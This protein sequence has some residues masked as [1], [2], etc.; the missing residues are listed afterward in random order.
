MTYPDEKT[1]KKNSATRIKPL[2]DEDK[3][4]NT[5]R[6]RRSI[7]SIPLYQLGKSFLHVVQCSESD[8]TSTPADIVMNDEVD[9]SDQAVLALFNSRL[10]NSAF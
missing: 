5:E 4:F 6:D 1:Y 9:L 3:V 10:Q 7:R 2:L 8:A